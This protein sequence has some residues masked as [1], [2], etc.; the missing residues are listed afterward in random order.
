MRL[1]GLV[2][3]CSFPLF[4][5]CARNA[6]EKQLDAMRDEIDRLRDV[7]DR[8]DSDGAV[9]AQASGE[10]A[11]YVPP[12]YTS[13]IPPR[14]PSAVVQLGATADG[15]VEGGGAEPADPSDPQDTTPRPTIKVLGGTRIG[16]RGPW[17]AGEDQVEANGVDESAPQGAGV[18]APGGAAGPTPREG[19]SLDPE[20]KRAY[21]AAIALVNGKRYDQAL[22]ALARFLVKWP[23][24][25][26]ANS[27]M[28]WR[29]ECYFA[30]ADYPHAAEQFEGVIAR[31]PAGSKVPDALLKLGLTQQKLGNPTKAKECFDRLFA[32][33]PDS[34]AAHHIPGG[35]PPDP[36]H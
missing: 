18:G 4:S 9:G 35:R 33:F 13:G 19:P 27:A 21:D 16:G 14:R 20:A 34:E 32:Q 2:A 22:D 30:R 24:H 12:A 25:P 10:A 15:T 36:P 8:M 6:E 28:Y 31:F 7:G 29:G 3:V 11:L 23:D 1:L 17:R 5:G 26:Y